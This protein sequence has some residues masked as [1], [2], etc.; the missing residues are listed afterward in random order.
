MEN[1]R[2]TSASISPGELR[3]ETT[4]RPKTLADYIGQKKVKDNLTSSENQLRLANKKADE[5]TIRKLTYRNPTMRE[6][7][8]EARAERE[9]AR[10]A[11]EPGASDGAGGQA[12]GEAVEPDSVE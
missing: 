5:L 9:A 11:A 12:A 10:G 6:K 7:F 8:A 1:E 2:I 3:Q 4:L